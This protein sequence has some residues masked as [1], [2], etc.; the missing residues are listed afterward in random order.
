MLQKITD[1]R[2]YANLHGAASFDRNVPRGKR[3]RE[4]EKAREREGGGKFILKWVL[5]NGAARRTLEPA[6]PDSDELR[7]WPVARESRRDRKR[8]G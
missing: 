3:N 4:K 1:S 5:P 2:E 6:R 7:S 8:Q